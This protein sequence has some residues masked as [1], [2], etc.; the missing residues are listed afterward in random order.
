[1]FTSAAL[2]LGGGRPLSDW[3]LDEL[4]F[5][6]LKMDE[7]L[8]GP[9]LLGGGRV[10][11]QGPGRGE[12]VRARSGA[13]LSAA[14]GPEKAQMFKQLLSQHMLAADGCTEQRLESNRLAAGT[15]SL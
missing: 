14:A 8:D 12:Q 6:A 10:S 9:R 11:W 15:A 2:G 3:G 1:M 4:L 7:G 13:D 5:S